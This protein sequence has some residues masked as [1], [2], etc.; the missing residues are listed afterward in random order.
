MP[1]FHPLLRVTPP[2]VS[3]TY[4]PYTVSDPLEEMDLYLNDGSIFCRVKLRDGAAILHVPPGMD[5]D[6]F[7]SQ[8]AFYHRDYMVPIPCG[9]CDHC[10]LLA[11]KEWT[12]RL[13]KE[14]E[15][16]AADEVL[17]LTL[18]YDDAH[19]SYAQDYLPFNV[20]EDGELALID[21]PTLRKSDLQLFLKRLRRWYDYH[22]SDD[23]G[24]KPLR[25]YACGEYG[26]TTQRPH[27][28]L[29]LYGLSD[30]VLRSPPNSVTMYSRSKGGY[31][32][33]SSVLSQLWDKGFSVFSVAS[34]ECM[35]YVAG[36]CL[37]KL[38]SISRESDDLLFYGALDQDPVFEYFRGK[39]RVAR[40]PDRVEPMFAHGSRK[41]GIAH[42]WYE[43]HKEEIW[44]ED[45][46][47]IKHGDKVFSCK[48]VR[49]FDYLYDLEDPVSMMMIKQKRR[50]HAVE[51]KKVN[52]SSLKNSNLSLSAQYQKNIDD[53]R[54]RFAR[55]KR[56]TL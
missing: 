11:R 38:P 29:I 5:P 10:K 7:K 14:A 54:A 24:Y 17:F 31:L 1:C 53:E 37:K 4:D 35:Q 16:Y 34:F 52:T 22:F 45:L 55:I 28:H 12:Y 49:Y 8:F 3:R 42:S 18:T 26:S 9:F 39:P 33:N 13:A 47:R 46:F 50:A 27:Y 48:P 19:L 44:S 32:Y 20:R 36:Y 41:P 21:A 56:D 6:D 40:S 25:F 2:I 23:P 30:S 43:A 15:S 51:L